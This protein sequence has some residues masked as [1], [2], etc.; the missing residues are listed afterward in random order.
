[1]HSFSYGGRGAAP[2][3][4]ETSLSPPD[5]PLRGKKGSGRG[6]KEVVI[7]GN[8][9]IWRDIASLA[10]DRGFRVGHPTAVSRNGGTGG[11]P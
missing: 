9:A 3:Q 5:P 8:I 4:L 1:M 6:K 2:K 11:R 10:R 7:L